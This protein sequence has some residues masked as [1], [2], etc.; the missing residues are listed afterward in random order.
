MIVIYDSGIE[1]SL[2]ELIHA[3][4]LP[5]YTQIFDAHGEGGTGKKLNSPVFPGTNNILYLA[6]PDDRVAPVVRSIRKMQSSFRL[7]PGISIYVV[8]M[9]E[10]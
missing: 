5:G 6:L 4:Q 3:L 10:M 7:K 2:T 8:P 9:E 1:E